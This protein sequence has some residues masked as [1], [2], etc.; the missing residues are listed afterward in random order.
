LLHLFGQAYFLYL[1]KYIMWYKKKTRLE[2]QQHF[3]QSAILEKSATNFD[4]IIDTFT[5]NSVASYALP[6]SV[7]EHFI[8]N[9]KSYQIPMVCEESSVIS[10][11]SYAASL[12]AKSDPQG[13]QA[14]TQDPI[15]R[16]H[17][18]IEYPVDTHTGKVF[19]EIWQTSHLEWIA[20]ANQSIQ[21][22]V[23]R[24]GGICSLTFRLLGTQSDGTQNISL[25]LLNN[26]L[27]A[28]G[29]N[30]TNTALEALGNYLQAQHPT[31]FVGGKI[32][33]N[34]AT[35][36]LTTVC[37]KIH[38]SFLAAKSTLPL[39]VIVRR[40][41]SMQQWANTDI[42]RA[43]TH[44]KGVMNGIDS[45]VLA[46]GNDWRA[47]EAAC[48]AYAYL[49]QNTYMPITQWYYDGEYLQ[50]RLEAPIPVGIVGGVTKLHPLANWSLEL[51]GNPSS[52]ELSSIIGAVGLAQNFAA[53]RA[54]ALEGI[55]E[56]HMRLHTKT[57]V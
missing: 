52:T 28:M 34:L 48:H 56:G 45:V 10:A 12:V 3:P 21:S 36:R 47:V 11:A 29:A 42:Y 1:F 8:I 50:G 18:Y 51:L 44:N 25:D 33:S 46:T 23:R 49:K 57:V 13:F 39:P 31:W 20:I 19:Q 24:G 4:A 55:Q 22:M 41:I 2:R 27:E 5:E 32:L 53:M 16:G 7:A 43:T 54:L 14:I 15:T 40:F 35:E 37:C 26:T 17:I 38:P 30:V 6:L 9:G